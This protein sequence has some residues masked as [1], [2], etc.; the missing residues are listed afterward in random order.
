MICADELEEN[1]T[2]DN[3]NLSA[4]WVVDFTASPFEG[5]PPL[6]VQFTVSGPDGEYAWDFGDGTGSNAKNPVHCYKQ[7]GSYWVKLKYYY[8]SVAGEVTKPD[9]VKVGDPGCMLIIMPNLL[10]AAPLTTVHCYWKSCEYHLAF[11]G[12]K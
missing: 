4:E 10:P 1:I 12:W 3:G 9:C 6:C 7:K 5:Y 8:G 11:R 2:T